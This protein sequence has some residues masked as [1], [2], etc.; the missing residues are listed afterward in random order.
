MQHF[1]DN[2]HLDVGHTEL[3]MEKFKISVIIPCYYGEKHIARTLDN[4][5]SQN[6]G[7]LEIIVVI[8]GLVDNAKE[9]VS[10]YPVRM[11]VFEKNRG[12]SAA[13]NAGIEAAT[14]DY[15][16]FMD[17]DDELS[18]GYYRKM[19]EA[20]GDG[21]PDAI[22]S[23]VYNEAQKFRSQFFN[24][25]RIVKG[26]HSKLT[27]TWCCKM[28]CCWR[29]LLR[30]DMLRKHKI[31][32]ET[33]H[34]IEDLPFIVQA[35]YHAN[36]VVTAPGAVYIYNATP[37]SI[38]NNMEPEMKDRRD[39]EFLHASRFLRRFG[40]E[41]G[42]IALGRFNSPYKYVFRA[43]LQYQKFLEFMGYGYA[44]PV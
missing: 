1:R 32:F 22:A 24:R 43:W 18:S 39:K 35:L 6:Y 20:A 26:T 29:Y 11:I 33:G 27:V 25:R 34:I 36:E 30:T 16:H 41:H 13:R 2:L 40:K 14:G 37:G 28:G 12:V 38:M 21:F 15:I 3:K 31:E 9:I 17:S 19:V 4:I 10:R 23:G 44:R 7:N 8:D 5:V 42:F